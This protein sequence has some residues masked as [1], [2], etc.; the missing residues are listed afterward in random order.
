M[1][2]AIII[3]PRKHA[4]LEFVLKNFT[5]NLDENWEF[6]I[7]HGTKNHGFILD[8]IRRNECLQKIKI[9]FVN[10]GVDDLKTQY[11]Y[12]KIFYDPGFYDNIPSENFLVFQTD[13]L[14][15]GTRPHIIYDYMKYDYVGS[16]WIEIEI[17]GVPAV[18]NG[19][20][21]LRKKSKML[22][23]IERYGDLCLRDKTHNIHLDCE[24]RFFSNTCGVHLEGLEMYKPTWEIASNFCAESFIYSIDP[25]GVHKPYLWMKENPY[26]EY[27]KENCKGIDKLE[28]LNNRGGEA[29]P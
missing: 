16:P 21:S 26:Y 4:A 5:N 13:T 9:T 12:S 7:F 2:S 28:A 18:G 11:E 3:E 10:L 20:L 27:L 25:W 8:I 22:E 14:L 15:S 24:D 23:M 17:G 29:P 1:Y 6:V 19:G